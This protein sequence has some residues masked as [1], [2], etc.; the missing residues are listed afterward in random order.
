MKKLFTLLTLLTLAITTAWAGEQT[1]TISRNDGQFDNAQGV[2]YASK[3][4]VTM[5]MSGG[6]NNSNFLV[7]PTI[8]A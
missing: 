5:T 2:Y 3:G 4:G 1:I 8:L 7:I 6:M